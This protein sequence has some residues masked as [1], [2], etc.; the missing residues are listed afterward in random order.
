MKKL[1]I[2]I[3]SRDQWRD[4]YLCSCHGGVFEPNDMRRGDKI[5]L[6]EV[7][8]RLGRVEAVGVSNGSV[9]F[10]WTE[11]FAIRIMECEGHESLV[12]VPRNPRDEV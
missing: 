7:E 10:I 6:D 4:F 1:P 12:P 2:S 3:L 5:T 11:E 9:Y 8:R